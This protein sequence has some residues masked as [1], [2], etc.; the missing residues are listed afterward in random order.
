MERIMKTN[1]RKII[2]LAGED[3]WASLSGLSWQAAAVREFGI[4]L[5]RVPLGAAE[6][7]DIRAAQAQQ[8]MQNAPPYP[9]ANKGGAQNP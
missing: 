4:E 5:F 2:V 3:A 6:I 7:V 1:V 8:H 9:M